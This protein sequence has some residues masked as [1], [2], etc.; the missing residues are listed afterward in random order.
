MRDKIRENLNEMKN[1][2]MGTSVS[3]S[4]EEMEELVGDEGGGSRSFLG[5]SIFPLCVCWFGFLERS[6]CDLLL[7]VFSVCLKF[8]G[9]C[10]I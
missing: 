10:A 7:V 1:G 3:R 2:E 8:E 5:S 4:E 6:V 9:L